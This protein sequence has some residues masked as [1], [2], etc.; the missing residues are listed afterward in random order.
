M[1]VAALRQRGIVLTTLTG[2]GGG[3]PSRVRLDDDLVDEVS[4]QGP[5]PGRVVFGPDLAQGPSAG[6]DREYG[7]LGC[8][9]AA[10]P[11]ADLVGQSV[12][13]ASVALVVEHPVGVLVVEPLEAPLCVGD[14]PAEVFGVRALAGGSQSLLHAGDVKAGEDHV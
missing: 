8:G 12:N 7:A 3:D 5:P 13:R 2:Q 6:V 10:V 14:S 9:Q 4:E 11:L 1:L